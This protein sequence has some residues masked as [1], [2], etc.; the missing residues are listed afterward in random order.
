[1]KPQRINLPPLLWYAIIWVGT[2]LLLIKCFPDAGS[3]RAFWA[4]GLLA[5]VV[6]GIRPRKQTA[7]KIKIL[8]LFAALGCLSGFRGSAL[9]H[10]STTPAGSDLRITA[11]QQ[12]FSTQ[13]SQLLMRQA[14]SPPQASVLT[15]LLCGERSQLDSH[16]RQDFQRSGVAHLLAL[17]GL[18]VGIFY[19]S[20]Q[21]LFFFLPGKFG[22][23]ARCRGLLCLI[24]LWGYAL[25]T[26]LSPSI[27]RAVIMC[28]C[29]EISGWREEPKNG[30]SALA[31]SAMLITLCNPLAPCAVGFQLSFLAMLGIFLVNPFLEQLIPKP[32]SGGLPRQLLFR[33]WQT[34][35]ITLSCQ[36]ITLP[37]L[38]HYFHAF[39]LSF[40][41]ANLLGA[42]L[43]SWIIQTAPWVLLSG[44]LW[45]DA[46]AI[47]LALKI[48]LDWLLKIVSIIHQF[49]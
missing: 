44:H 42:P 23:P 13:V 41:L 2:D 12:R 38:L 22:G 10:K 6:L 32:G 3:S 4:T 45:P 21:R 49:S 26:G 33:L 11:L 15:A 43:V 48:P 19:R 31:I 29:Y 24:F 18:H 25:L 40:Q 34:I 9:L 36:L 47:S 20:L 35:S 30:L 37:L 7:R 28:T 14:F 27:A 5:A 46:E 39:P 16:I 1:M 17:S 8:L